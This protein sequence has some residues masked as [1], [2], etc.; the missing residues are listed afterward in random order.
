MRPGEVTGPDGTLVLNAG[1]ATATVTVT[2]TDR[3]AVL[4]TAKTEAAGNYTA[5]TLPIGKYSIAVEAK[6]FKKAVRNG[7][8]VKV[9]D[10]REDYVRSKLSRDPERGLMV[11][12]HAVQDSSM[13]SVLARCDAFMV[14]PAHDPARKAGDV[15]QVIELAGLPGY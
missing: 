11:E 7:I 15:V 4:R 1:R 14:R 3:N 6:G 12:P 9:N 2:N 5:S 8:D 10:T 13:L